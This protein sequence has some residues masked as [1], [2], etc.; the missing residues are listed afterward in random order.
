LKISVITVTYNSA[1]TLQNTIDSVASQDYLPLEYIIVDGNSKDDS[2][3]LIQRNASSITHWVSEPDH[4]MYDAMNKGIQM[5]KGDIVGILNSDDFFYDQRVLSKII[6]AF[7]NDP[8]VEAIIG[9]IVFVKEDT[10]NQILR[11]Y[12]AKGW[13]PSKFA[14]GYMPPHPSFFVRRECFEKLGY[15]KTDYKIAAD[16]ELLIR[17]LHKGGIKWKYL[18]L[19]TTK[20]RMG[21]LSTSGFHSLITLNKEIYRACRENGVYTNYVMIYSKYLFKPF[22]FVFK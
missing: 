13:K 9:D 8:T 4:G 20:M 11:R 18:P 21:G 19:I 3:D 17:F 16:Y 14:L 15:Y 1:A 5:A 22:E 7:E 12:S 6:A 2:V 10:G